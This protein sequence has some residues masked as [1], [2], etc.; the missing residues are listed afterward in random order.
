MLNAI[1]TLRLTVEELT[2]TNQSQTQ[3]IANLLASDK[4]G[5]DK[6]FAPT[7]EQRN[8]LNNRNVDKRAE[9]MSDFDGPPPP[10]AGASSS[11][12]TPEATSEKPKEVTKKK[13][14]AGRKPSLDNY[15]CDCVVYHK[16]G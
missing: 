9:E 12:E 8:L 1:E 10:S 2:R 7:T 16:L 11:G 6:R 13:K 14:S 15:D 3:Q 5:R 4:L